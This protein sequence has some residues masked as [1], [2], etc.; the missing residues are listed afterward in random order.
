[1]D[2]LSRS[3]SVGRSTGATGSG[4]APDAMET[5]TTPSGGAAANSQRREASAAHPPA[6]PRTAAASG[7][8]APRVNAGWSA[9]TP[10]QLTSMSSGLNVGD[11]SLLTEL[12]SLPA[13]LTGGL[14]IGGSSQ[15]TSLQPLNFGGMQL[16]GFNMFPPSPPPE[17]GSLKAR[18]K[19]W[20]QQGDPSEKR[21]EAARKVL[22]WKPDSSGHNTLELSRLGLKTVPPLPDGVE[23]VDLARNEI[24]DLSGPWP[25]STKRIELFNNKI[26]GAIDLAAVPDTVTQLSLQGNQI[27]T[28]ADSAHPGLEDLNLD[29]NQIAV[30]NKQPPK[31]TRLSVDK[32]QLTAVP[33]DT[34]PV[35]LTSFS[36][37][38]NKVHTLPTAF[39]GGMKW[40]HLKENDL[41]NMPD[42]LFTLHKDCRVDLT[43]NPVC[44]RVKQF[45]G[46][47][48]DY[49][50]AGDAS[51]QG[52]ASSPRYGSDSDDYGI[53][54]RAWREQ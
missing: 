42:A 7:S 20:E 3:G 37:D 46:F 48:D 40:L 1:M 38:G 31:L 6:S 19:E 12:P 21:A 11:A 25:A 39:P 33:D 30:L 50:Y 43:G 44:A 54:P 4:A 22:N 35:G 2:G 53:E 15:L 52:N 24:A 27:T 41:R 16:S 8:V 17:P 34:L 29:D 14:N 45:S 49:Y 51:S 23:R 36:A 10:A 5:D 9:L 28:V 18:L 47:E 13:Q 26:A 32:N